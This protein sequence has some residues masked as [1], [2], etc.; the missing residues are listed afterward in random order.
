M[1]IELW[2]LYLGYIIQLNPD[3][4]LPDN[5]KARQTISQA[6]E[7]ALQHVGLDFHSTHIW[8]D[9]LNFVK[10]WPE[11]NAFEL[12]VKTD[13]LRKIYYRAISIPIINIESIWRDYDAYENNAN[14]MTAKKLI[15]EKSSV[16]MT[17]RAAVRDLQSFHDVISVDVLPTPPTW[18]EPERK[19]LKYWSKWLGW[20]KTNPLNI[21]DSIALN[22]RIM[23]AFR[24]AM[25]VLRFYP[26]IWLDAAICQSKFDSKTDSGAAIKLLERGLEIMPDSLLLTFYAAE[27]DEKAGRI[28][29][30]KQRFEK[31]ISGLQVK[32]ETLQ[33]QIDTINTDIQERGR[34]DK[35][36][37]LTSNIAA[38]NEIE[39]EEI[40][41][42]DNDMDS[43]DGDAAEKLDQLTKELGQIERLA[44]LTW[45][46]Y[47]K[48]C[49]RT[50]VYLLCYMQLCFYVRL[51]S[52]L[53]NTCVKGMKSARQIFSRA[54]KTSYCSCHVFSAS[55]IFAYYS[56][57]I[58]R[59]IFI[60]II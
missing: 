23:Y 37:K 49:R 51:D 17:A 43:Q 50:E 39:E 42:Q 3:A 33:P 10:K 45:L 52:N 7:Y 31:L 24:K 11:A 36:K 19:N 44:N 9:Y 41:E 55:G 27:I 40:Y 1:S 30:T 28:D 25:A 53:R 16:Y 46:Q 22:A 14:R 58:E 26:E 35:A 6:F 59:E 5:A 34:K 56:K 8:Q 20:E 29:E 54:R 57:R 21:V 18:S 32:M 47:M 15:T 48:T 38:S 12:G 4:D 60:S 13:T 2:K